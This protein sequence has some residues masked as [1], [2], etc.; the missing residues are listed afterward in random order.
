[1]QSEEWSFRNLFKWET[2]LL[3]FPLLYGAG[4]AF[5]LACQFLDQP[6]GSFYIASGL[7]FTLALAWSL[8]SLYMYDSLQKPRWR[9]PSNRT[10][11]SG[12]LPRK[13]RRRRNKRG[14]KVTAIISLLVYGGTMYWLGFNFYKFLHPPIPDNYEV[15]VRTNYSARALHVP[16]REN[17]SDAS[18]L[19]FA[20]VNIPLLDAQVYPD[21]N[22]TR[23]TII[24]R[25]ISRTR[26]EKVRVRIDSDGK[27]L[28][29]DP[30]EKVNSPR[31]LEVQV[32]S[33]PVYNGQ[34]GEVILPLFLDLTTYRAS[35]GV[36][37]TL[38]SANGKPYAAAVKVRIVRPDR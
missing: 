6:Q 18:G 10:A 30:S 20:L 35:A 16:A 9:Y 27:I 8:T 1:M 37:V 24:L 28:P 26:M 2:T 17:P 33:M 12:D 34:D 23:L 7:F 38:E 5:L 3:A 25:N 32:P 21:V 22:N 36:L 15:F 19:S 4:W 14:R 31:E 13:R 11:P 29:A